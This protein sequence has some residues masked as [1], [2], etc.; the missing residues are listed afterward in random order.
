MS[1]G[2][3]LVFPGQGSQRPGMATPWAGEPGFE[4]WEEA[5][6]VLGWDVARLGTDADADERDTAHRQLS[7]MQGRQV[8]RLF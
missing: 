1:E 6:D 2:I 3:A 8:A 4:R 5:S 7:N